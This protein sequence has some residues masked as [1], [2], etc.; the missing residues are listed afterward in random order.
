MLLRAGGM[1]V[2]AGPRMR[3]RAHQ[4]VAISMQRQNSL[5]ARASVQC[6]HMHQ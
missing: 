3:L 2:A 6:K 4:Q 1:D 5:K